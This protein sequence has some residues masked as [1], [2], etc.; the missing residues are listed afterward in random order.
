MCPVA[1]YDTTAEELLEQTDG[2]IDVLVVSAGTGGTL[3][4]IGRKLKDRLPNVKIVGVD[5]VGSILAEPEPL[6]DENRLQSYKVEPRGRV[7]PWIEGCE[8]RLLDFFP[9]QNVCPLRRHAEQSHLCIQVEGIGYD[10]IPTVLD[11][12]LVDEWVKTKGMWQDRPDWRYEA[13]GRP[14]SVSVA[15]GT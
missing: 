12:S 1:H 5:P 11:R 15:L 9:P 3:T 13:Q 10:F 6:N 7:F 2:H 4:G 14:P 8:T